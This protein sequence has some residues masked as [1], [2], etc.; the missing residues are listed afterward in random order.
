MK[1]YTMKRRNIIKLAGMLGICVASGLYACKPSEKKF[2]SPP[3]YDL[4]NPEKFNMPESLLEISGIAF[5]HDK[6]DTVYSIQDE[7]GSFFRQ[8]WGKKK[9]LHTD[10]GKKGDYEDVAILHETVL[11]LDSDGSLFVFP[12]A[13]RSAEKVKD[14]KIFEKLLPKGEYESI[15]ADQQTNQV[16]LLCKN[17]KDDKK[18]RMMSGSI[19]TYD[20]AKNNLIPSGTFSMD[21]SQLIADEQI[22]KTG[23]KA[24]ALTRDPHTGE[25]YI[26]SSVN[27]LL[28][29]AT[30]DWKVKSA[31]RLNSSIFNQPEGLAFDDQMNLFISNEGDE[32][33]DGNILKF[34]PKT[35]KK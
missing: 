32:L 24:S 13:Q 27:K 2:T 3:Q 28:I 12:F 1:G 31:Y 19:F 30:P 6:S 22:L 11:I 35:Q 20:A 15:Y 9:Q 26:L 33:S 10:F 34:V 23:V 14:V 5:Y 21:L 7:D 25:W 18:G 17:C 16:Y 29:V 8:A 4:N